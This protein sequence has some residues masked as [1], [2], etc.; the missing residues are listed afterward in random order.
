MA[1]PASKRLTRLADLIGQALAGLVISIVGVLVVDGIFA[2][3]GV[4]EFGDLSGW[5]A[6][7]FPILIFVQQ[8]S[9]AKGDRGRWAVAIVGALV[10]A[11]LGLIAAGAFPN[12]PAIAAGAIG[13][14]VAT[15]VYALMWHMGLAIVNNKKPGD[16]KQT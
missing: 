6:L 13:A 8:F 4:G 10:A 3:L 1:D 15:V 14:L 2:L 12:L 9:L 16:R 5:L 7:V 11:A